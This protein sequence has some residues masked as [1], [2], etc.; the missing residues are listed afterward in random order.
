LG[1]SYNP[2]ATHSGDVV[3]PAP[4]IVNH[5]RLEFLWGRGERTIEQEEVRDKRRVEWRR[6]MKETRS[7]KKGK[8][9]GS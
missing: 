5:E 9:K 1:V 6:M 3:V 7:R 8:R 2:A 4:F